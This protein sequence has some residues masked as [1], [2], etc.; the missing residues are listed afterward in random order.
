MNRERVQ[1]GQLSQPHKAWMVD[2]EGLKRALKAYSTNPTFANHGNL[3]SVGNP[4]R[5][6]LR[7]QDIPNFSFDVPL[8]RGEFSSSSALAAQRMLL[9]IYEGDFLFLPPKGFS[10]TAKDF[11][12]FYCG[13]HR[14]AGESVRP[15]LEQH[16]FSFLDSEIDVS[17]A[18]SEEAMVSFFDARFRAAEQSSSAVGAAILSAARPT[19]A[20]RTFLI[21]LASDFLTEASAMARYVP[22]NFGQVQSELFKILIDEYGYGVHQT[23]HSTMFEAALDSVGLSSHVHAYWQFYLSSSLALSNYFH[24]VTRNKEH[25]FRYLGAL[26]YT[27]STLVHVTRQ[28]SRMLRV[29]FGDQI[30]TRYFDEHTHIDRHHGRMVIE[31]LIKPL[32]RRCGEG[33]IPQIVRGFEEFRILQDM[34]DEDLVA[35]LHWSDR[36]EQYKE[37]AGKIIAGEIGKG[38]SAATQTLTERSGELSVT[39]VHDCDELIVVESGVLELLTGYDQSVRLSTGE[40]IVIPRHRLHGSI[41]DSEECRYRIVPLPAGVVCAS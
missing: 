1:E 3:V 15:V 12:Q 14:S 23:K 37:M 38:R 33:I 10:A 6:A 16:V 19:E 36:R 29:V 41:V 40:G 7:P 20:A 17:G 18:W 9:N 35:Q 13:P 2:K 11:I 28:Q 25:F 5:R 21:Q 26:Y 22:G 31:N 27:E 8:A 4:Y 30:D 32:V 39:H 24:F 34:A